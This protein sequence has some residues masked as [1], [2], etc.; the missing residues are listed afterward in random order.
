MSRACATICVMCFGTQQLCQRSSG[1]LPTLCRAGGEL[2]TRG[3]RAHIGLTCLCLCT[4]T[5]CQRSNELP[6][7]RWE[8]GSGC[9]AAN[10]THAA[11]LPSGNSVQFL[12]ESSCSQA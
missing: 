9:R 2:Q 12:N 11:L 8:A 7:L 5:L 1:G 10:I 3:A 4:S 6:A